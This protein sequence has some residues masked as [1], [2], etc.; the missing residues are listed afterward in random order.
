MEVMA[1]GYAGG[2]TLVTSY[3][4]II[5]VDK[6]AAREIYDLFDALGMIPEGV[7]YEMIPYGDICGLGA[8]CVGPSITHS[9]HLIPGMSGGGTYIKVNGKW[10][11]V[12]VNS[13]IIMDP[14]LGA[15]L[16]FGSARIH[17]LKVH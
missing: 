3:G 14:F 9:A 16:E 5:G 8:S 10:E 17:H 11:L 6:V 15:P 2:D 7:T 13:W 1:I 12:A 4:Q